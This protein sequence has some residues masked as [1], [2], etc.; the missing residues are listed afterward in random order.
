DI[1]QGDSVEHPHQAGDHEVPHALLWRQAAM[2]VLSSRPRAQDEVSLDMQN[3]VQEP[4][5]FRRIVTPI[6]VEEDQ[7][8]GLV[9]ATCTSQA[10][11]AIPPSSFL[12]H[13]GSSGLCHGGGTIVA[14]VINDNHL[15]YELPGDCLDNTANS[16]FF[17]ESW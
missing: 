11:G 14:P 2:I 16:S 12:N 4:R 9:C 1:R 7:N 5:Q 6:T 15:V 10:G 3:R 17:I 13:R 8:I